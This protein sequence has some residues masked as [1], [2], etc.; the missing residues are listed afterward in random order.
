MAKDARLDLGRYIENPFNRRGQTSK[1]L[2]FDDLFRSTSAGGDY[3][4]NPSRFK[5]EDL[6]KKAQSRKITLNPDLQFVGNTPFFDGNPDEATPDYEMFNGIGRFNRPEDYDFEEGRGRTFQRPQDQPD[7]NPVWMEAY[8]IS[9]TLRPDKTS[10]NPMPRMRN[11]DPHGFLMAM[12]ENRAESEMGEGGGPNIADLLAR[13]NKVVSEQKEA[14]KEKKEEREGE[15][16]AD[17]AENTPDKIKE[18]E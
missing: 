17:E 10:K 3:P 16:I 18:Q 12:A 13:G 7:F 6:L 15:E 9:P 14:V 11:P 2:D 1:R 8:K 4:W 5:S